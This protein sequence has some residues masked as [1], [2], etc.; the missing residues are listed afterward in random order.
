MGASQREAQ[1][2]LE[3]KRKYF[4]KALSDDA[5]DQ[6]VWRSFGI[7]DYATFWGDWVLSDTLFS[8]LIGLLLFDLPLADI[9]PWNLG[10]EVELPSVEEFMRGVLIKLEPIQITVEFPELSD[11][12]KTLESIM[13]PDVVPNIEETRGKKLIVGFT[14]YGEGYVDP[15][16]VREFLRSTLYAFTKKNLSWSEAKQRLQAV[17]KA[18]NIAPSIVED[19]FNRLSI[20]SAIKEKAA[21]WDYA[22]W[23]V[24][25]WSEEGSGGLVEFTNWDLKTDKVEYEQMWDAQAGAWWDVSFWDYAY[26]TDDVSPY[27]IDPKVYESIIS[28]MRDF[29]VRNFRNRILTIAL[30]LANYQRADER[31]YPW[32]SGR[33]E[34]FAIPFSQRM[35]LESITERIVRQLD[36]NVTPYKL[37]LYKTAVIEMYGKLYN[38]HRWGAEMERSMSADEFKKYWL[39]KWS[40]EGLDRSILEKLYDSVRG[41]VDALGAV[42]T[43]ERLR[44]IRERLR[45]Y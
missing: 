30:A 22:W 38:P 23:D 6:N 31:A 19:V 2:I 36:P 40:S 16:A 12:Y 8:S 24:S 26:W 13:V 28:R 4:Q 1:K 5:I 10:W 44:F 29:L 21:T 25:Y 18:L 42:R 9:V 41:T 35:R 45:R 33:L 27:K 3:A 17:A 39:E 34:T 14:K 37:R 20:I 15:P 11:V 43:R 7:F 32:R